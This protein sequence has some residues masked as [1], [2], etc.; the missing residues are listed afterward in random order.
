MARWS[1]DMDTFTYSPIQWRENEGL[2]HQHMYTAPDQDKGTAAISLPLNI[3]ACHPHP[4]TSACAPHTCTNRALWLLTFC[5][6]QSFQMSIISYT[7][8]ASSTTKST[9]RLYGS[10]HWTHEKRTTGTATTVPIHV[11]TTTTTTERRK[12][13]RQRKRLS[14]EGRTSRWTLKKRTI[15]RKNRHRQKLIQTNTISHNTNHDNI[16]CQNIHTV[17]IIY[18]HTTDTKDDDSLV[19]LAKQTTLTDSQKKCS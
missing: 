16:E 17:N 2:Y 9:H 15:Y 7:Q 18:N 1:E 11:S 5:F 12:G 14:K 4:L 13:P 3:S 19:I 6:L 8:T 10:P